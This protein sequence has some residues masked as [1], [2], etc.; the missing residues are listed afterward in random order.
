MNFKI[1]A[2]KKIHHLEDGKLYSYFMVIS[3]PGP[4]GLFSVKCTHNELLNFKE[5][6]SIVL[7]EHDRLITM[8]LTEGSY[9]WE[10]Y[11][12]KVLQDLATE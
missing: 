4:D 9:R 10:L 2:I 8:D 5:L 11:L 7:R 3:M 6:Q 1:N 12:D